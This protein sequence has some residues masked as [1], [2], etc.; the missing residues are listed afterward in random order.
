MTEYTTLIGAFVVFVNVPDI[1]AAFVPDVNPVIPTFVG[2]DQ[3]YV[4]PLGT[5]FPPLLEGVTVNVPPE[6][7]VAVCEVVIEGFGFTVTVTVKFEPGH[8]PVGEVG[9]TV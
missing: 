6:Q 5:I 2:A 3:L 4:V 1:L 9:V 7:I 8:G